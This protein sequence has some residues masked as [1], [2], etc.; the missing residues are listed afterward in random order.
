MAA[1]L[2]KLFRS[3]LLWKRGVGGNAPSYDVEKAKINTSREH[4]LRSES[5][6]LD[7]K[8]DPLSEK[9]ELQTIKTKLEERD[10]WIRKVSTIQISIAISSFMK[11]Q[12]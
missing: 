2:L 1:R 8:S 4:L 11:F 6:S 5:F 10:D 3:W 9:M 12:C 7:E